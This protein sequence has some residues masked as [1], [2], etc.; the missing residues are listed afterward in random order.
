MRDVGQLRWRQA[1]DLP[2]AGMRFDSPY[3]PD[4]RFGNNRSITWTGFK[5]H[6][7]ET[8]ADEE[9]P[10]ITHVETTAAGI[11]DSELS[12]P[13]QDALAQKDLLPREHFL[14]AG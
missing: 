4:A 5:V 1:E 8:C 13:I 10:L 6:L 12:A 9:I 2:P 7:T 14:D 11:T 3:D